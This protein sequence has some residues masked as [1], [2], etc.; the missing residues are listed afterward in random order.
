MPPILKLQLVTLHMY[1]G[2][3][4]GGG[5]DEGEPLDWKINK[6]RLEFDLVRQEPTVSGLEPR[7]SIH[8]GV[9]MWV[10]SKRDCDVCDK[11]RPLVLSSSVFQPGSARMQFA[12]GLG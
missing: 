9:W 12:L 8:N 11:W 10:L 7:P 5:A 1:R 4:R 6:P 3:E 2:A